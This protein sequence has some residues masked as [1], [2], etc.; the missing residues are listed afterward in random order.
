MNNR[1][2]KCDCGA[3]EY[4]CSESPINSVFCYCTSCQQ[5]TNSDKYFG[6]WVRENGFAFKKG[7]TKTFVRKGSSGKDMVHH[8]C[9]NCGNTVAV[10]VEAGQF[11]TVSVTTLENSEGLAPQ[12]SIYTASAPNWATF[13]E[14]VPKYNTLPESMG[15]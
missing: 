8:F 6:I 12:M 10:Y 1:T 3:V 13:P 7:E 5:R 15:G 9:S 11:Y 4:E 14:G 2:G